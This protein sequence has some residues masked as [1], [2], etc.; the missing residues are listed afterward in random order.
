[1]EKIR[2][3]LEIFA[4]EKFCY[5]EKKDLCCLFLDELYEIGSVR[6]KIKKKPLKNLYI[7]NLFNVAIKDKKRCKECLDSKMR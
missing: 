6:G 4:S 5:C 3:E 7:C 2:P 1:M